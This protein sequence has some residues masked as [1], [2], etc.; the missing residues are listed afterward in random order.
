MDT[1]RHGPM[2]PGWV[3]LRADDRDEVGF[4]ELPAQLERVALGSGAMS[5][6]EIVNGVNEAHSR[7][8]TV[9]PIVAANGKRRRP[10][11][12][13]LPVDTAPSSRGARAAPC[14]G[15]RNLP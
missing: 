15:S 14:Q 12:G 2:L 4:G 9:L 7:C 13:R 10:R 3:V 1:P 8:Q 11:S 6:E 5:G